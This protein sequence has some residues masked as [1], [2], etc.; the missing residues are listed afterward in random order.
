M[1]WDDEPHTYYAVDLRTRVLTCE[2]GDPIGAFFHYNDWH[3]LLVSLLLERAT[4]MPGTACC[5]MM[6]DS[7]FSSMAS[8]TRRALRSGRHASIGFKER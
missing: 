6:D 4:G 1:P 7:L 5:E 3:P 8:R 2:I